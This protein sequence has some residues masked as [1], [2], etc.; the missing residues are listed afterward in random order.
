[1]VV[2]NAVAI[3]FKST[4]LLMLVG[5]HTIPLLTFDLQVKLFIHQ[6]P[7]NDGGWFW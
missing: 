4:A 3:L 2:K 6:P 1:M 5:F 7:S